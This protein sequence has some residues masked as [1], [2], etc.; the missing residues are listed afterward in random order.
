[1]SF[2]FPIIDNDILTNDLEELIR[3]GPLINVDILIGVTADEALYFAEEHIFNHYLPRKYR[4]NPILT[5]TTQRSLTTKI[6]EFNS[7]QNLI[8]KS[9]ENDQPKGFSYFRK[10]NY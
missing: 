8:K 5:T 4:T 1:M 2:R 3:T 9:I 6:N 10:N 7:T